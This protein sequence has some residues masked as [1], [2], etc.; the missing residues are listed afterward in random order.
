MGAAGRPWVSQGLNPSY[1]LL[2]LRANGCP[3]PPHVLMG[4][5][6]PY[7]LALKRCFAQTEDS[8]MRTISAV[9]ALIMILSSAAIA[10]MR[11]GVATPAPIAPL[12]GITV[13]PIA[14]TPEVPPDL[15]LPKMS[16]PVSIAP[17]AGGGGPP[18]QE[19]HAAHPHPHCD[20][21]WVCGIDRYV[22]T[23]SYQ[24]NSQVTGIWVGGRW[25]PGPCI[26]QR[27]C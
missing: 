7:V 6:P 13:A 24:L 8:L 20:D 5:Q 26:K 4:V 15:S 11:G 3:Y 25:V 1:G 18:E 21:K 2:A 14:P 16:P 27:S 9:A 23:D 22:A 12:G 17:S 19:S 10:Q